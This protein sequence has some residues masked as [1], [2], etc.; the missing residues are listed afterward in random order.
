YLTAFFGVTPDLL[1]DPLASH[2]PRFR[3]TSAAKIFFSGD[4]RATLAGYDAAAALAETLPQRFGRWHPQHQA[5]YLESRYLLPGY[6]LSSQGD[7]MAM[8]HGVEGRFP[9]L[10]HRLIEFAN[11]L[12]PQLTLKGL[13]EKH[14]LRKATGHLLPAEIASRTKQSYRAPDSQAFAAAAAPDYVRELL[15]R[16]AIERTGLFNAAAVE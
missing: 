8:A 9:F 12:P 11:R 6:I 3:S 15:D 4:L 1:N 10:D 16:R 2:R 5:Q 14:I 13:T 7:R